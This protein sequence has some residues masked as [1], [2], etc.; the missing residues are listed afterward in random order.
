[1]HFCLMTYTPTHLND[2]SSQLASLSE[3]YHFFIAK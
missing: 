3:K 1:M 2:N